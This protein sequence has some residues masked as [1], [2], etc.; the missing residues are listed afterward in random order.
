MP[1]SRSILWPID[2]EHKPKLIRIGEDTQGQRADKPVEFWCLKDAWVLHFYTYHAS[3]NLDGNAF[4][5]APGSLSLTPPGAMAR[6]QFLGKSVHLYA[7]FELPAKSPAGRVPAMQ[8]LGRRANA[9]EERF[10]EC[11]AMAREDKL[12]AEVRLWDLLLEAAAGKGTAAK[13]DAS[14]PPAF[15]KAIRLI[16]DRLAEPLRVAALAREVGYS[17][18]QLTRLFLKHRG[19]SVVEY[20]QSRRVGTALDLLHHTDMAVKAVAGA[21]GIPDLHHFNKLMKR[22]TGLSP[23]AVRAQDAR[24]PQVK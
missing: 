15:R 5:I 10:R 6:Y 24:I 7:I 23:R 4:R 13:G 12:R 18:N 20:I 1:D 22:H 19:H 9:M 16:H 3:L 17:H 14:A 21:V 2:L 11:I 8:A